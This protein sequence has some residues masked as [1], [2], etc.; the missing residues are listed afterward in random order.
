VPAANEWT[1]LMGN[2]VCITDLSRFLPGDPVSNE[3]MER[4]LGQVGDRPSRA[5]RV[6]LRQNG[7]RQRHYVLDSE[8]GEVHYNNAQLTAE[9]VRRL[10]DGS[11][12]PDSMDLLA[13]GTSMADQLMPSHAVMVHGELGGAPCETVATSGICSAGILALK[14][15]WLA[16]KAGEAK[17]AVATG[18]E[19]ASL[20]MRAAHFQG[21][22]SASDAE[23]VE[24]RPELAFE[25]EFLRW[26]LSD[27]AGAML[28]SDSPGDGP[29][30]LWIDWIDSISHAGDMDTCMYAGAERSACG[31]LRGWRE[32]DGA[33]ALAAESVMVVKQDVRLLNEQV[34]T[35]TI[36]HSLPEVCRRRGLDVQDVDWFLPH[37]SSEYFRKPLQEGLARIGMSIPEERWFTNLATRGNT[38]AASIFIMLEELAHSGCLKSGE[39]ILCFVPE[40]GRFTSCWMLLT[41]A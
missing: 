12:D 40:S 14:Q 16:V 37:M 10:N 9:A 15:A 32:F 38:G 20:M 39:R 35:K 11:F 8:T 26:M 5:R 30:N 41:V 18:S 25:K 22:T 21:E 27:G 4:I 7:I 29:V 1:F 31:R 6:I 23:D 34:V 19:T 17:Q 2:R 33:I 13:C 24:R 36:D 3:D 28:L